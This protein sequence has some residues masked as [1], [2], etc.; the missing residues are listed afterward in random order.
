MK[1]INRG[2][3]RSRRYRGLIEPNFDKY[4]QNRN[5]DT[6]MVFENITTVNNQ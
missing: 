1:I 4:P 5:N 6:K 3:N 2:K